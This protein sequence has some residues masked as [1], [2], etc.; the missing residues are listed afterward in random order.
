MRSLRS[1]SRAHG[2]LPFRW[3]DVRPGIAPTIVANREV[4]AVQRL[5]D[6]QDALTDIIVAIT[7][8]LRLA[9]MGR[10]R[11]VYAIRLAHVGYSMERRSCRNKWGPPSDAGPGAARCAQRNI[12]R[13]P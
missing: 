4:Q 5:A 7:P 8:A 13:S 9:S 11:A 12:L 6:G 1:Q 2:L 10:W 3:S